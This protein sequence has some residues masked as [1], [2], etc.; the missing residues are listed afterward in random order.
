MTQSPQP[1]FLEDGRLLFAGPC[2]FIFAS[3]SAKD[4]PP[5][6]AYEVAFAGRSNVGKSSLLNRLAGE[7]RAI[8]TE[9]AGTTRDPVRS[10]LARAKS[11]GSKT[12]FVLVDTAGRLQIDGELMDEVRRVREAF[13]PHEVFLVADAALDAVRELKRTFPDVEVV[14]GNV[15]TGD[16]VRDLVDPQRRN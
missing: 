10:R 9:I 15:A 5:P 6:G 7:E 2:D 13:Q 16:G 12:E 3:A 14:A 1:D 4:L 8:V 11:D